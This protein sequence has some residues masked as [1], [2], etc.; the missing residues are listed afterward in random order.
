[1]IVS[2]I[3]LISRFFTIIFSTIF[4]VDSENVL[5]EDTIE[6][7]IDKDGKLVTK[8]L[9]C[10]KGS[11]PKWASMLIKSRLCFVVEE[12]IVDPINKIFTT[13]KRNL[14]WQSVV[15]VVEEVVYR[16][17]I[18]NKAW[19]IAERRA[20]VDSKALSIL[21]SVQSFTKKSFKE[22]WLKSSKGYQAIL[23]AM[24]PNGTSRS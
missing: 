19:T 4:D 16:Q 5:S 3:L 23:S 24:Y 2:R 1:M 15:S 6:R 17:C 9:L 22:G 8:R 12:S 11:V 21:G 14:E 10:K 7:F 20:L 18:D 13:R